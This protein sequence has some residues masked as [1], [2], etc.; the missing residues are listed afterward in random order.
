VANGEV[1]QG[2]SDQR[3]PFGVTLGGSG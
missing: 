1:T 2:L 3:V